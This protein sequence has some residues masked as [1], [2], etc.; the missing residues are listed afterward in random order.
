MLC[1]AKRRIQS[2]REDG[3]EMRQK[4]DP[5]PGSKEIAGLGVSVAAWSTGS[6]PE[7]PL[8]RVR[9]LLVMRLSGFYNPS[10]PA[11]ESVVS[12]ICIPGVQRQAGEL[13]VLQPD[14]FEFPFHLC[15]SQEQ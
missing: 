14:R 7:A 4:L 2:N 8:R 12:F 6:R 15:I 11:L 5:V 9:T 13:C 3:M 1:R 10:N